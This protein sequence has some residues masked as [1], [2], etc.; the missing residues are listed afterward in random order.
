M[1]W[2]WALQL[3]HCSE[4]LGYTDVRRCLQESWGLGSGVEQLK[5]NW[6]SGNANLGA[7]RGYPGVEQGYFAFRH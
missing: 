7:L 5:T 2:G 4:P 1:L 6:G 3:G